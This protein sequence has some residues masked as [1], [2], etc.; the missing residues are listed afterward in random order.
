MIEGYKY[1]K[2]RHP[3]RVLKPCTR[4]IA[5][6]AFYSVYPVKNKFLLV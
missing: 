1:L 4:K 6:L 2:F 5:Q 3:I